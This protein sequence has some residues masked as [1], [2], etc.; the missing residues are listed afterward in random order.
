MR[1]AMLKL[2]DTPDG[3]PS[4]VGKGKHGL[5]KNTILSTFIHLWYAALVRLFSQSVRG[6]WRLWWTTLTVMGR[7]TVSLYFIYNLS[8]YVVLS[9]YKCVYGWRWHFMLLS[10]PYNKC[11]VACLWQRFCEGHCAARSGLWRNGTSEDRLTPVLVAFIAMIAV[12]VVV[13]IW[14]GRFCPFEMTTW[15]CKCYSSR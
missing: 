15:P 13:R 8:L 2:C 7:P 3:P 12:V 4:P 9:W 6:G 14:C 5:F 1:N 11:T 10:Q